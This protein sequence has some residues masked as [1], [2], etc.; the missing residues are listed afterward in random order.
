MKEL[1]TVLNKK[2]MDRLDAFLQDRV[3]DVDVGREDKDEGILNLSGLDGFLTA[4]VCTPGLVMPSQWI[5][6]LWGDDV[7]TWEN[8]EEAEEIITLMLR[9]MNGIGRSLAEEPDD[10]RPIFLHHP[11]GGT[12]ITIV[13][14]WCEGCLRGMRFDPGYWNSLP[15][16]IAPALL[17]IHMFG[18]EEFDDELDELPVESIRQ[19][20]EA[21]PLSAR[22]LYNYA[23]LVRLKGMEAARPT[24]RAPK[25]GRNDLCPCG[26]GLKH[27]KC[28]GQKT[29]TD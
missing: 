7:L 18:N 23:R 27:K 6:T 29:V 12:T 14:D 28:C 19:L 25:T 3:P 24:R 10:F 21:L 15:D 22:I 2:E 11:A 20:Q 16:E 9:H 8:K 26:S 17:P 4:I 1:S 13:D 5:P